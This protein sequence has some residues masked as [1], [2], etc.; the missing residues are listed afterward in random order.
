[1]LVFL[2]SVYCACSLYLRIMLSELLFLRVLLL[3]RLCRYLDCTCVPACQYSCG[4]WMSWLDRMRVRSCSLRS[5]TKCFQLSPVGVSLP[6][7]RPCIRRAMSTPLLPLSQEVWPEHVSMASS[8]AEGRDGD[9]SAPS[10]VRRTRISQ[11]RP[12]SDYDAVGPSVST[13][14]SKSPG[15]HIGVSAAEGASVLVRGVWAG[16]SDVKWERQDYRSKY[17]CVY[18]KFRWWSAVAMGSAPAGF[19]VAAAAAAAA[20]AVAAV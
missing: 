5:Y 12:R 7:I 11:K 10:S 16:F 1:M 19:S 6:P 9:L 17:F 14:A 15:I 2:C 20:A 8:D 13:A 3:L 18:N 4:L